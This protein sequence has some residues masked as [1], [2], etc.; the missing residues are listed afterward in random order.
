MAQKVE[1]NKDYYDLVVDTA[2]S[3]QLVVNLTANET[4]DATIQQ[5]GID[6]VVYLM[7]K[8]GK[9]LQEQDAPNGKYGEE[10]LTFTAPKQDE[11]TL[12]IKRLQSQENAKHGKVDVYI[13][14]INNSIQTLRKK[15]TA[16][17]AIEN[18]KNTLTLDIDHFWE[19]F[20]MLK[21]AKTHRDSVNIFQELYIDRATDGLKDFIQERG[22][23]AEEYVTV[24]KKYPK[25]YN[26]VRKY[27]YETKKAEPYIQ[28]VFDKLKAIYPNF[29]PF[30]VCFAIG[31]L[32]T[33]GT[34]SNRF[35]LI[36]TE[37]TT[38][39]PD[40]DNSEFEND[41]RKAFLNK[42]IDLPLRIK[43]LIAHECIHT[44]QKTTID[45][46]GIECMLLYKSIREGS[47]DFIGELITGSHINTKVKEY[48][49]AHEKE[50]WRNFKNMLC[51]ESVEDWLYNGG[52]VKNTPPDLGYYI[53]YRIAQSYYNNA[54]N[55]PKAIS[56][57]IEMDNAMDFLLKSKYDGNRSF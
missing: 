57:I 56:E 32:R 4:Y 48:G 36:G 47:C 18:K 11:Y 37:M 8:T 10:F 44:Q 31:T 27:T 53:G 43:N 21:H 46:L 5:K 13:K 55:K 12:L 14:H 20:D 49:D 1:I 16:E 15:A 17:L 39:G 52:K 6:V 38:L 24:I 54:P 42:Q 3:Q 34:V 2:Q 19:A 30:K 40:V 28:E 33:G 23:T 9:V 7:D 22:F 51:N 50:L 25:Y 41:A 26:S 35:V 45:T 29:K